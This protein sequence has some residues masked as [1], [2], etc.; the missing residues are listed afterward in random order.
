[1]AY[2]V[3]NRDGLEMIFEDK[4]YKDEITGKWCG[5]VDP[6]VFLPKGS[7][8]KLTG[9]VVCWSDEPLYINKTDPI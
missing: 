4:P 5:Y 3:V 9:V 1:M 8:K 6:P 2:L 7:I